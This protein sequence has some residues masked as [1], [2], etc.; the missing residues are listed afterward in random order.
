M[1]NRPLPAIKLAGLSPWDPDIGKIPESIDP[2]ERHFSVSEI[3]KASDIAMLYLA[4]SSCWPASPAIVNFEKRKSR[5]KSFVSNGYWRC[6][7]YLQVCCICI[8]SP[9][10]WPHLAALLVRALLGFATFAI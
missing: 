3:K 9:Q 2:G 1:T 7:V 6:R 5:N 4:A 10:I 8:G